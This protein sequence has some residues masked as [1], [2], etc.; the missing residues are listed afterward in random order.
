MVQFPDLN[1]LNSIYNKDLQ[2][3]LSRIT[4]LHLR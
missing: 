1:T 3:F 2:E 4:L